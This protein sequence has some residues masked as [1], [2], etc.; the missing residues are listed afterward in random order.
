MPIL[1]IGAGG[2]G[3]WLTP[4]MCLL[5]GPK[6]ITVIDGDTLEQKNLNR[7]LFTK[8]DIGRNKAEALASKYGCAYIPKYFTVGSVQIRINTWFMVCVDNNPGRLAVLRETDMNNG[9]AIFGANETYSSEAYY[10]KP[11]WRDTERDPRVFDPQILEDH[12]GDPNAASIGCTGE[13]QEQNPQLVGANYMAA[14]LMLHLFS[15]YKTQANDLEPEVLEQVP[16]HFRA[17]QTRLEN[18]KKQ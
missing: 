15:F 8:E 4:A 12:G 17:N 5:A 14:G 1:I 9:R 11:E 18:I 10:Y 2:V 13:A 6:N 3:S 16:Y 7:Q